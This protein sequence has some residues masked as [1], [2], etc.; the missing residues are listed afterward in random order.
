[1]AISYCGKRRT[2]RLGRIA[3]YRN[4]AVAYKERSIVTGS[5]KVT[6]VGTEEGI[7]DRVQFKLLSS[8]YTTYPNNGNSFS[9]HGNC[10]SVLV[11]MP[12]LSFTRT[13]FFAMPFCSATRQLPSVSGWQLLKF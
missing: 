9:L 11:S 4:I 3:L 13:C 6:G 7:E 12:I 1:M 2:L 8:P 10:P 5:I